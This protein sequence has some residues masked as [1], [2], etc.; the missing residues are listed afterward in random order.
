MIYEDSND[1][2]GQNLASF[3]Y[4]RHLRRLG[5]TQVR[6]VETPE[7]R[8]ECYDFEIREGADG[9]LWTGVVEVKCRK[10]PSVEYDSALVEVDRLTS[11]KNQFYYVSEI[12]GKRFWSKN[13]VY[14]W[15]FSDN[16]CYLIDI[17]TLID[18][19][20]EME[21]AP[22]SMMKDNHGKQ[23][24]SKKGKLVPYHLMERIE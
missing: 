9:Q 10:V 11:L 15:K 3:I 17:Q 24:A 20:G 2:E 22:D 12:T 13:V 19:W 23:Q 1:R 6:L 14:M 5:C 7:N 8:R 4:E 18:N 16:V 21:D